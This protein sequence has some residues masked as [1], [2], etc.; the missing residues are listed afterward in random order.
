MSF[1][2]FLISKIFLK[3]L[4]L[5][6]ISIFLVFWLTFLVLKIYTHHGQKF[7]VPDFN[8]KKAQEVNDICEKNDLRF[9]IIDS[10]FLENQPKGTIVDQNPKAGVMVKQNRTIFLTINAFNQLK[11]KMPNVVGGSIRQAKTRFEAVGLKVGRL[12]YVQDFARNNILKQQIDGKDI[13]KN[14]LVERGSYINLVVGNGMSNSKTGMP[15]LIGLTYKEARD[16]ITDAFLNFNKCYY[17]ETILTFQDS[18][19]A[20]VWKQYPQYIEDKT[21]RLGRNVNFWLTLD[22][23]KI[24]VIE[25]AIR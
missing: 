17:D 23:N 24:S 4:F 11:V 12:I 6:I 7:P 21:V 18:V 9:E 16:E 13:K 19:N 5:A 8:G 25:K 10:I 3:N 15:N 20:K 14:T 2:K 1:L 22:E